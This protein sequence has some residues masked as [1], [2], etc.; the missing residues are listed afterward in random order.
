MHFDYKWKKTHFYLKK[1]KKIPL[2]KRLYDDNNDVEDNCDDQPE[3]K[4]K[5]QK[6]QQKLHTLHIASEGF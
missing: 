3:E 2:T 5:I 1:S 4:Y 6:Q